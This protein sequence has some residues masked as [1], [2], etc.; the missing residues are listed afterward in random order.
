MEL[1]LEDYIKENLPPLFTPY[2]LYGIYVGNQRV[3]VL[4]L[5]DGSD[6]E[7]LY[8]GHIGYHI[9]EAYRGHHY[10][11]QACLLLKSELQ[12]FGFHHVLITCDPNHIASIKT[13]EALGGI[14]L[15]T[16]TIPR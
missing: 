7:H 8:D 3:G 9:D 11:Y 5:R 16:K 15:D 6:E 10:A 12:Q 13:I 1:L 14:Y 4:T 2:R